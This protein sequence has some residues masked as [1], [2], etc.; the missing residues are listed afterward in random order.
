MDRKYIVEVEGLRKYFPVNKK[1]ILRNVKI[2]DVKALADVS[3][4]VKR[5]EILGIVGESGSG[6]TTL[7]RVLLNLIPPTAGNVYILPEQSLYKEESGKS[8][9]GVNV[10]RLVTTEEHLWLRRNFQIVFQDP[11]ASLNPRMTVLDIISEA[12]I[13]HHKEMTSEERKNRVIELLKLVGLE[14]YHASRYPHEFSG[15]QRQRVGIARALA[16]EPEILILDEPVSALD[17]AVQAQILNLLMDLKNEFN[18]TYLFIAHDLSVVRHISDRIAVMYL[19]KLMELAPADDFFTKSAHPYTEALISAVPIP[20]PLLERKRI[21]LE[22]DPPNPI[23][24]PSGCVFRTRCLYV[25]EICA[26]E[27]PELRL[28]AENHHVA[29]HF[30]LFADK[31]Y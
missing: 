2:G 8:T 13:I 9:E 10:Y 18:L 19:G 3:L 20:N 27:E 16:V 23:N 1:G 30:P 28:I 29:C 11:Y 25:R 21:I 14:D 15:G 31:E 17:V 5:N 12:L 22:G 4:S 24:P 7:A 26:T 6:K